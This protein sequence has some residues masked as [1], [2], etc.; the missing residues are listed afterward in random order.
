MNRASPDTDCYFSPYDGPLG[1]I[2]FAGPVDSRVDHNDEFW[3]RR[4]RVL[5]PKRHLS[6]TTL[7]PDASLTGHGIEGCFSSSD[8]GVKYLPSQRL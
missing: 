6:E 8:R 7:G 3:A 2:A 1:F 4:I 5:S